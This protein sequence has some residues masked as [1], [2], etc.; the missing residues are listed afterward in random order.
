MNTE[1]LNLLKPDFY[2]SRNYD[3]KEKNREDEQI[4]VIIHIYMEMIQGKSPCSYL[5]QT[6]MSFFFLLQNWRTEGKK[7]SC[8]GG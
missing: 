8:L 4:Q 6:K 2:Q 3:R 7:R 1:F 5:N